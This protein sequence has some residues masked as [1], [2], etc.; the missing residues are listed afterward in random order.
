M[1]LASDHTIPKL[2]KDSLD[3]LAA[4][5]RLQCQTRADRVG[6]PEAP[7]RYEILPSTGANSEVMG[8]AALPPDHPADVFFDMEGYPLVAGGLEYLFGVC[9]RN[10]QT[11]SFTFKDWWGHTREEELL[12]CE[13]FVDWVFSRWQNNPGMHI[14]HYAPYEVSA[15]RRLST[16]HDTRQEEVDELLRNDVFV[17]L[18]HILRQGLRIGEDSYSLKTVE[19]FYRPKRNTKVG[20]AID[21]IVQYARWIESQQ[22]G[23]WKKS[24]I[25]KGI[26]DYNADDCTIVHVI[27]TDALQDGTLL[28]MA[29]AVDFRSSGHIARWSRW[30]SGLSYCTFFSR[31]IAPPS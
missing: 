7:P 9:T 22:S 2:A 20:T 30:P 12:A 17:D 3:K 15:V 4:Q 14:Y 5:A 13:G 18:Y 6:N 16:R 24:P 21:S 27:V 29:G 28:P 19:Q 8:L 10:D 11:D 23:D 25:L 31:S 1:A 26:R